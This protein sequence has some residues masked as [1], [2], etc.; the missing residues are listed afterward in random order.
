M[1]NICTIWLVPVRFLFI[2]AC[3]GFTVGISQHIGSAQSIIEIIGTARSSELASPNILLIVA[4]DLGYSDIG[5]FGGEIM[6][7]TLNNLA[8]EGLQITNFHVLLSD[9]IGTDVRGR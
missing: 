3:F 4:D 2:F 6:T 1:Y 5:S 8:R 7:P 9:A